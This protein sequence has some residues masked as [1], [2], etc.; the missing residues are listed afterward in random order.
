MAL[1]DRLAKTSIKMGT[2]AQ[3]LGQMAGELD[4]SFTDRVVLIRDLRY[5]SRE[6]RAEL[7]WHRK[8]AHHPESAGPPATLIPLN[9][10]IEQQDVRGPEQKEQHAHV[11]VHGE[12]GGI[13]AREV[14]GL[15][16]AV[17]VNK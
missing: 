9:S 8:H 5:E 6:I 15:Y 17:L 10:R 4:P 13:H 12:E 7:L 2:L 11:A 1:L 3:E 16:E 14:V